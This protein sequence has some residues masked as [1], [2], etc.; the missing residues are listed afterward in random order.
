MKRFRPTY[1]LAEI[2]QKVR[3]GDWYPTNLARDEAFKLEFDATD[4]KECVLD[5]T[6][7]DFSHS[8]PANRGPTPGLWQDVYNP[9]YDGLVLY[10]K[11][12]ISVVNQAVVI[13]FKEK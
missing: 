1:D 6:R 2:Q 10:V 3:D 13:D 8:M 5:L 11:L 9:T 4:I 7:A 12:Q